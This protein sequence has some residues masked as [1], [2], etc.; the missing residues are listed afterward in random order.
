MQYNS[1]IE[2]NCPNICGYQFLIPLLQF[3]SM[4]NTLI[5][6]FNYFNQ[7]VPSQVSVYRYKNV[8]KDVRLGLKYI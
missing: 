7:F 6:L 2:K 1:K 4:R 3:E 8:R 5:S